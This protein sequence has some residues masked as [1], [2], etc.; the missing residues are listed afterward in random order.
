[1]GVLLVTCPVTGKEYSTGVQIARESNIAGMLDVESTPAAPI[2]QQSTS[3]GRATRDTR[4]QSPQK[5][6]L[7]SNECSGFVTGTMNKVSAYGV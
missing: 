4:T 2:A 1:M 5:I 7:R 6:G 3:G